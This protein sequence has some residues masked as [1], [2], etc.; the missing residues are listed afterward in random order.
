MFDLKD[1]KPIK[2]KVKLAA[3]NEEV[4]LKPFSL[5][6]E[7]WLKHEFGEEGLAKLS[8]DNDIDFKS[9]SK[10]IWR[11]I[12]N[13]SLFKKQ[14]VIEYDDDGNEKEIEIGGYKLFSRCIIGIE[15]KINLMNAL[16]EAIGISRPIIK[17]VSKKKVMK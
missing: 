2:T 3:L 1:L 4:I 14:K 13:K 17:E 12:E 9:L 16:N 11:V 15:E 10:V 8:K 5:D 6:D 7:I